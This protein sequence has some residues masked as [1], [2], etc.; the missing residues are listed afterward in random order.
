M[1]TLLSSCIWTKHL[2]YISP[3]TSNSNILLKIKKLRPKLVGNYI[4]F[5][6]VFAIIRLLYI[7]IYIYIYIYIYI[8]YIY[9]YI[10]MY[11][12]NQFIPRLQRIIYVY[13]IN[14]Y[15][16]YNY[17]LHIYILTSYISVS[18]KPSKTQIKLSNVG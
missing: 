3:L 6:S 7:C 16:I 14:I 10:Y 4:V 13:I 15:N 9:I 2:T 5:T 17:M 11:I 1:F 18:S 12:Y 8:I